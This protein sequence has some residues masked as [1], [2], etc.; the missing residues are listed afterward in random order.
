LL[1]ILLIWTSIVVLGTIGIWNRESRRRAAEEALQKSHD[2]L[3]DWAEEL[4]RREEHLEELVEERTAELR[5]LNRSLQQEIMER[6]EAQKGLQAS[7]DRFRILLET[8]PQRIFLKNKEFVYLYCNE[9]YAQNLDIR[10]FEIFGKTDYDLYPREMAERHLEEEERIFNSGKAEEKEERYLRHGQEVVIQ[11]ILLPIKGE[12]DDASNLLGIVW[13]VTEKIRLESIAEAANIMTNIGYIFAGIRHEIGNPINCIKITLSV[14]K[15]K[16]DTFPVATI[17][18]YIDRAMTELFRM[19]YLLKTLKNFNMYENPDLQNMPMKSFLERFLALAANDFEK[20]GIMIRSLIQP[21]AAWGYADP[22]ALQ[23]VLLN[24]L[25]NASNALAGREK[26]EIAFHVLKEDGLIKIRV[27]D[28]G[29]GMSKEQ[30]KDL[31][32]PFRTTKAGGTGLGL[33]IAKKMLTGM[34]GTIE[35]VSQEG[36]G[37]TVDISIPEGKDEHS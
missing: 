20:E 37:T 19:E 15:K 32:K 33:V 36:E 27:T 11:K 21:E 29:C 25:S 26:G 7:T 24:I 23:Q 2:Q 14:L 3:G 13:D 12:N 28:N 4:K 6:K 22:R 31:F 10:P 30:Q 17:H 18:E 16:M 5:V 9:S 35:I 34:N 1:S 8:L